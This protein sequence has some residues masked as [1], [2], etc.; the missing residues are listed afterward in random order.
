MPR[1]HLVLLG[2]VAGLLAAGGVQAQAIDPDQAAIV[3]VPGYWGYY[4]WSPYAQELHAL[5]DL[6]RATGQYQI[7]NQQAKRL[8]EENRVQKIKN[9]QIEW[10]AKRWEQNFRWE[11]QEE[12]ARKVIAYEIRRAQDAPTRTEVISGDMMNRLKELLTR[13]SRPSDNES[14]AIKQEWLDNVTF[15]SSTGNISLLKQKE[16]DWPAMLQDD[17]FNSSRTAIEAQIAEARQL[18]TQTKR[19]PGKQIAALK[20]LSKELDEEATAFSR[21]GKA[22]WS[23]QDHIYVIR[24]IK[25]EL[26]PTILQL[27]N[28]KEA[29][30]L[31][32]LKVEA[33]TVAELMHVM[34]TNGLEF[35]RASNG[36]ER[37]YSALHDAMVQ[38]SKRGTG[39]K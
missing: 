30:F 3:N 15:K 11:W 38:E 34:R 12:T 39:S 5:A 25:T 26:N 9:R 4:P 32:D 10:E 31:L 28:P 35:D 22:A 24:W 6:T 17:R 8:R 36:N 37:F 23:N 19:T 33:K 27:N 18:I 2:L 21:S 13:E 7:M 1:S 20:G 16:V 14:I 29:G